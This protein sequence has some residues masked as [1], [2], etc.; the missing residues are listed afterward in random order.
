M[1]QSLKCEYGYI[2]S[3]H[4]GFKVK[5][6]KLEMRVSYT[7]ILRYISGNQIAKYAQHSQEMIENCPLHV[8]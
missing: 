1:V 4:A 6:H 5:L 7:A 8:R 2:I 3:P